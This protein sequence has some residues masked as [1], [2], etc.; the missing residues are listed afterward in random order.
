MTVNAKQ[1]ISAE[2][3]SW[4]NPKKFGTTYFTI[5]AKGLQLPNNKFRGNNKL[6]IR[7]NRVYNPYRLRFCNF[8]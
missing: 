5:N 7:K 4:G 2:Y 8:L 3:K 6:K 1:Y